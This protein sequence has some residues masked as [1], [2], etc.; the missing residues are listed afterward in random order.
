M[1]LTFETTYLF[2]LGADEAKRKKTCTNEDVAE[3]SANG[4][5]FKSC[6]ESSQENVST[7]VRSSTV[8]SSEASEDL[9]SVTATLE[10]RDLWDRFNELGTEMI[11]TKSG[12]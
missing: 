10:S 2:I 4:K 8:S 9:E 5:R 3:G 11:I 6:E 7:D 1:I 12:R